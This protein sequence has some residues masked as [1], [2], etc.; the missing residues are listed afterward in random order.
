MTSAPAGLPFNSTLPPLEQLTRMCG[1]VPDPFFTKEISTILIADLM[2]WVSGWDVLRLLFKPSKL[3]RYGSTIAILRE[4][5]EVRVATEGPEHKSARKLAA[6]AVSTAPR[7]FKGGGGMAS[8]ENDIRILR[9]SI[10]GDLV[11]LRELLVL[12]L[13]AGP[14]EREAVRLINTDQQATELART[15]DPVVFS[16]L[17]VTENLSQNCKRFRE[18]FGKVAGEMCVFGVA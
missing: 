10:T 9:W 15:S 4:L 6:S 7:Y 16:A 14:A 13:R 12:T 18:D 8:A 5:P 2:A 3:I 11:P 17:W 1:A